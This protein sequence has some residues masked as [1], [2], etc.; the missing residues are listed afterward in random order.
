MTR[1]LTAPSLASTEAHL[2]PDPIEITVESD[3]AARYGIYV[4]DGNAEPLR[5]AECELD[6]IGLTLLSLADDRIQADY[7]TPEAFGVLDQVD[8]RWIAGL[9]PTMGGK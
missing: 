9:W 6:A 5:V 8:R 7:P 4:L 2:R 3:V 1:I